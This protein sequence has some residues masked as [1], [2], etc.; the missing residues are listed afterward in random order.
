MLTLELCVEIVALLRQGVSIRGIVRQLS[1]SRQT[2]RRYIRMQD[3][4]AKARYSARFPRPGKLDPFK[5][6]ILERD[7]YGDGRHRWNPLLLALAEKY[8]FTPRVCRPYRAKT[9]GKVERFNRYLKHSFVVP[10]ATTFKQVGLLLDV[11]S[12]NSRIGPWLI[13][14]ANARKHGTTGA[15]P[16][17]RLQQELAALLPRVGRTVPVLAD[18][19]R[20]MPRESFQHP[21]S[22]YQSLLEAG[23]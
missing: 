8:G 4:P 5:P 3:S 18:N 10:L 16:E 19:Q 6:Y 9:K 21:L 20:V 7:V 15:P 12:A 13:T 17:H 11:D 2:I 23:L 22:V 14:V 1:C